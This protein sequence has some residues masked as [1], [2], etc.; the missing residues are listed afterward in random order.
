[1]GNEAVTLSDTTLA[2]ASLNAVNLLSTGAINAAS[3]TTLTGTN[4][5]VLAAYTANTATTVTGLG[6]EAVLLSN[7]TITVANLNLVDAET[8]GAVSTTGIL[9]TAGNIITAGNTSISR[10]GVV[11]ASGVVTAAEATSL[12]AFDKA[13]SFTVEDVISALSNSTTMSA[14]ANTEAATVTAVDVFGG[15]ALAFTAGNTAL[16][17]MQSANVDFIEETADADIVLTASQ[18][19]NFLTGTAEFVDGAQVAVAGV[20]ATYEAINLGTISRD[21]G[22]DVLV[23]GEAAGTTG[24]DKVTVNLG[25]SGV[26]IVVINGIANH[27]V[28]ATNGVTETFVISAENNGG[29]ML[30]NLEIG[31]QVVMSASHL[32]GAVVT[33]NTYSNVSRQAN[34]L[35][36]D[37][38]DSLGVPLGGAALGEWHFDSGVLTYWDATATAAVSV[39]LVGVTNVTSDNAGTLI[40]SAI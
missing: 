37:G 32:L 27:D 21:I 15:I 23:I 30:R 40:V 2:A 36:V 17:Y 25:T 4:T 19:T 28:T 39:T 1:L 14:L 12:A 38:L 24:D 10:G 22:A 3:V 34:V 16:S 20:L 35:G 8:T 18:L 9:D 13:V 29:I 5:N 31:D 26:E 6:N 11:V 33:L 7:S